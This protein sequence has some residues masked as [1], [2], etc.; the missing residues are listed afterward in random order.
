MVPV[1]EHLVGAVKQRLAWNVT[2]LAEEV[3]DL[4]SAERFLESLDD[5]ERR[6]VLGIARASVDTRTLTAPEIAGTAGCTP[7]ETL[8][9]MMSLNDRVLFF[10]KLVWGLI[11]RSALD[12]TQDANGIP[13]YT[14]NM[15]GAT[16]ELLLQAAGQVGIPLPTS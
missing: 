6:F 1:P 5:V 3:F 10:G 13:E 4:E 16:A 8:G 11:N 2:P 7:L 9:L 15:L 12:G 14:F